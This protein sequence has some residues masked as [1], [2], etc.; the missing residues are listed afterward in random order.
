MNILIKI[1]ETPLDYK[2][3]KDKDHP[4][5]DKDNVDKLKTI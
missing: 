4:N 2:D 1:L 3:T 5:A